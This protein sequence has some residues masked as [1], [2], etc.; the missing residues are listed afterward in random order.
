MIESIVIEG[1]YVSARSVDGVARVVIR[2]NPQQNFP[3]VYPAGPAGE[4]IATE[5]NRAAVRNS[6]LDT[7][8]PAWGTVDDSGDIVSQGI[9]PD[10]SSVHAPTEFAGFGVLS[11][12]SVPVTGALDAPET[13]SVLALATPSTP[14]PTRS[15]SPPRRGPTSPSSKTTR[16]LGEGLGCPPH[17]DPSIRPERHRR[18]LHRVGFR[19]RRSAQPVLAQRARR[20]PPGRHHERRHLGWELRVVCPDS[21]ETDGELIEVGSV[22]DMGNGE[23][24]QSVRFVGDVGYVVTFRQIDPFY[25]LDLRDPENPVSS[26]NSRFPASPATSTRSA[27]AGCSGS[28]PMPISTAGSPVRRFR[29]S[30]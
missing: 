17:L 10:C 16:T 19:A 20:P 13:T 27:T 1:D 3:F 22:G 5:A 26:A 12:V 2:S 4:D 25:T 8:L 6:D 15:S 23:A 7:W 21:R 24:V 14:R 30:T 18:C 29:S 9:F 11:V 28:A